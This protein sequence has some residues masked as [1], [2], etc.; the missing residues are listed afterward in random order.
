MSS[1]VIFSI[2]PR[3]RKRLLLRRKHFWPAGKRQHFQIAAPE[4][5]HPGDGSRLRLQPHPPL[6][7]KRSSLL[8]RGQP[9]RATR[10][11]DP[12]GLPSFPA[13]FWAVKYICYKSR[14]FVLLRGSNQHGA[15]L[16]LRGLQVRGVP[17]PAAAAGAEGRAAAGGR[18][19]RTQLRDRRGQAG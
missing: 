6:Q 12:A 18:E 5:R 19:A 1:P 17:H 3:N 15:A 4:N 9:K 8:L 10:H 2:D 13:H 16:H 14:G 7:Q 11:R